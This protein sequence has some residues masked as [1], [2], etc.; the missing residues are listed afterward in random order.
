VSLLGNTVLLTGDSAGAVSTVSVSILVRITAG[1]GLAP[2]GTALEVNVV[3]VGAGVDNVD[4]DT[5]ATFAVIQVLVEAA[6]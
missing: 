1:D 6:E 2:F 5:L 3:D 4:I